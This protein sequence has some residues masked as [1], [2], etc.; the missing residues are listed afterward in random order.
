MSADEQ[1]GGRAA[2][3]TPGPLPPLPEGFFRPSHG[4]GVLRAPWG[5]GTT[6]N[7]GGKTGEYHECVSLAR[8]ASPAA[9]RTLVEKMNSLDERVAIVAAQAV[10][11]RAWG[12]PKELDLRELNQGGMRL[13]FSKLSREE[14][15]LLLKITSSGAIR[16]AEPSD[17]TIGRHG[18]VG[19][20]LPA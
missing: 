18:P 19:Q 9:V 5:K 10:L 3:T 1:G 8:K 16:P 20:P 12:K 2:V 7:P 6:G 14:I 13:D 11:E 15:A 4:A 17:D